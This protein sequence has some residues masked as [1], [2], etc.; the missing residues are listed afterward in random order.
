MFL[1]NAYNQGAYL[2]VRIGTSVSPE[3]PFFIVNVPEGTTIDSPYFHITGDGLYFNG[4]NDYAY[5]DIVL[6]TGA[7]F[8]VQVTM[9]LTGS[10]EEAQ[11]RIGL[12]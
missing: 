11:R 2:K 4:P 6:S 12:L 10:E 3:E 7:K 9:A 5:Y 1:D 8:R